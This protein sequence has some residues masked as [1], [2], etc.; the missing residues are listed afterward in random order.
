MSHTNIPAMPPRTSHAIP[1]HSIQLLPSAVIA[2][3]RSS[4]TLTDLTDVVLGLLKNALDARST[5]IDVSIDFARGSC[6][7]HDNGA[8]IAP[9]EFRASGGLGRLHHT[10]KSPSEMLHGEH[11]I[12]LASV[13]SMS[14][15]KIVSRHHDSYSI[16]EVVFH[17]GTAISRNIL[18]SPADRSLFPDQHGT[19][20][21]VRDLFGNMPVRV[22]HRGQL[23][24]SVHEAD[25]QWRQLTKLEKV[26]ALLFASGLIPSH[27]SKSFIAA[28]ASAGDYT[29]KGVISTVPL[30]TRGAQF[31]SLG[32]RPLDAR[33][34][35]AYFDAIN[36]AFE[37]S[38]FGFDDE[39]L[40]G[41]CAAPDQVYGVRLKDLR[42]RRKGLDCWP[43]FYINVAQ[44]SPSGPR[45]LSLAAGEAMLVKLLSTFAQGWLRAN[46]FKV[47]KV[48]P[49]QPPAMNDEGSGGK[50]LPEDALQAIPSPAL[51]IPKPPS[52][53]Q[54]RPSTAPP[55]PPKRSKRKE[56]SA[57]PMTSSFA[58]WSRI[59]SGNKATKQ[60]IWKDTIERREDSQ[61]YIG[62]FDRTTISEHCA[63][64]DSSTSTPTGA[65]IE[66]DDN[67]SDYYMI[68]NPRT[69][70]DVAVSTRTGMIR[71]DRAQVVSDST[72]RMGSSAAPQVSDNSRATSRDWLSSVLSSWQNPQFLGQTQHEI[73]SAQTELSSAGRHRT[74][75]HAQSANSPMIDRLQGL[76]LS[77][78]SLGQ[79]KVIAQIDSKYILIEAPSARNSRARKDL[80]LVDQHAAS[81]RIILESLFED[82]F[83][84][85]HENPAAVST[86]D[87][88]T[89]AL[90][91]SP[92]IKPVYFTVP[93]GEA[94]RLLT[95]V[96]HFLVWGIAFEIKW[97]QQTDQGRHDQTHET[98]TLTVTHL[99]PTI[100]ERCTN[101]P[102][103]LID[104]IR[105]EMY[106]EASD[107]RSSS[108]KQSNRTGEDSPIWL[109]RIHRL[110]RLFLDMLNSRACRS[111][112]MFNDRLT[113]DDRNKLVTDL[114]KC[115]FPFICAHGR[116]SM[117]PLL[118]IDD[119]AGQGLG[120]NGS[121]ADMGVDGTAEG[122]SDFVSAYE[123][124]QQE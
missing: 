51:N 15:L 61:Q 87:V 107:D 17:R 118:T 33:S 81:E 34:A 52:S 102:R 4:A 47:R 122:G 25:K 12:F 58:D 16:N 75:R 41:M 23:M 88:I 13:A 7:V 85:R 95:Q 83:R 93:R 69:G 72:L 2:Q 124:W 10:S 46:H 40:N 29:V 26:A 14:L 96:S 3:I 31:L 57:R 123:K 36:N 110:P 60:D 59:K 50:H 119:D 30:A 49:L 18:P 115:Q 24:Q 32:I 55:P 66:H 109:K 67:Q 6:T 56:R 19:R 20:V 1:S 42:N 104:M 68:S 80:V 108:I 65:R 39:D 92:L 11:G 79:A 43:A 28:S 90:H 103:L 116:V 71:S 22:K 112:I 86:K 94:V 101:E 105:E 54:K 97:N 62:S 106:A 37:H 48:G 8:G 5:K 64:P 117:V 91:S 99:P 45:N 84:T 70:R 21:V 27:L 114:T 98:A 35:K 89:G 111:A 73:P 120:L 76:E 77:K 9:D 38:A 74:C 53:P 44:R 121:I 63:N 100:S 78:T 82:T 113:E